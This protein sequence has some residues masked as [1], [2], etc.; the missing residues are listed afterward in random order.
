MGHKSKNSQFK[1]ISPLVEPI[2]E[3]VKG[4]SAQ[5]SGRLRDTIKLSLEGT[6]GNYSVVVVNLKTGE[7]YSMNDDEKY[8]SASLYKLWVMGTVYEQL[9]EGKLQKD[10]VLSSSIEELNEKFQIAT[11]EAEL[12]EGEVDMSVEE[13]LSQMITISH[14]YAALLLSSYVRLSNV[15]NFIDKY[16][17]SSSS[18]GTTGPPTTTA[19]DI[20]RFYDL[21]YRGKLVSKSASEEML[22]LLKKQRLNDRIPKY[23][24]EN[25]TVAHKTGELN[26][27][28]HDAGIIF[29]KN[30]DYLIVVMSKS[31]NPQAAAERIAQLSKDIYSY[32]EQ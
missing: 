12:T 28:K 11:E 4:I 13:A 19:Q 3:S 2:S 14:N 17:L 26:G 21:L 6:K 20:A 7:N 30:G 24:P 31:R 29:G 18:V 25:I 22:T 23:L 1:I 5:L 16:G 8:D 32:F 15:K 10:D 27:F 9:E